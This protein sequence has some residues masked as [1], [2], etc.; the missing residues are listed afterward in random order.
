MS[1][2]S[3]L[4]HQP[5][6]KQMASCISPTFYCNKTLLSSHIG[7]H[8]VRDTLNF[9]FGTVQT[10]PVVHQLTKSSSVSSSSQLSHRRPMFWNCLVIPSYFNQTL[11]VALNPTRC[12]DLYNS[13]PVTWH[14]TAI[15]HTSI[16]TSTVS[17]VKHITDWK[18]RNYEKNNSQ[19]YYIS[20]NIK[21]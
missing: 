16:A 6:Q 14:T 11:L 5:R 15:T 18:I 17:I 12:S 2:L 8:T 13:E 19:R 4:S 7:V 10:Y 9:K 3:H 1:L 21:M 20:V